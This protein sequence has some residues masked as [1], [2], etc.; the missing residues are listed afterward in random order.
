MSFD[1]T[2]YPVGATAPQ[3][4][5]APQAPEEILLGRYRV[6]A[7]RGTGG[8][9]TVCTCWDTVLQRRVAIKRMPL[10]STSPDA[11]PASTPDEVLKEA[12]TSSLLAHPN[13][14]SVL[15]FTQE[16]GYA[17]LIM[18]YVDGLNL[19]ELLARVE[20]GRLTSDECAHVLTSC[21]RALAFAHENRVLHMDIKPTNIMIDRMGTVKIADFGMA[22]LG[23]AAGYGGARGGTVGYMP[24][25]QIEG[26]LVDE[27]ADVFA[28]A[29]VIWQALTG[30]NPFA[31]ASAAASLEKIRRGPRLAHAKSATGLDLDAE[32]DLVRALAP[33]ASERTASVDELA[34]ELVPKLGDPTAGQA[35]LAELVAQSEEDDQTAE[36]PWSQR[37]IPLYMRL[38]GL[39]GVLERALPALCVLLC[40]CVVMP[41]FEGMTWE[42]KA[43]VTLA[44]CAL[45]ALWPPAAVALAG[46]AGVWAVA[47]T[48]PTSDSFVL[49]SL[50][51]LALLAWWAA[52]GRLEGMASV[53]VL[54]PWAF[55]QPLA[56]AQMAGFSLDPAEALATGAF[57]FL[58]GTVLRACAQAGYAASGAV[59]V[60]VAALTSASTWVMAG[61]AAAAA[62][63]SSLIAMRGTVAS[64]IVGQAVGLACLVAA[65][66]LKVRVENGGIWGAPEWAACLVALIWFCFMCILTVLRGPLTQSQEGE[67][68]NELP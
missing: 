6:L 16:N 50:I 28:L 3:A 1:D 8:F 7:R 35:S 17:Y 36:V 24:P 21:A 52:I 41:A 44:G 4:G 9:G 49:A 23:A 68:I 29:V 53:S 15:D 39:W 59:P 63:S 37:H 64:G 55:A 38:P 27:R 62:W 42:L 32:D 57:S 43:A 56:G 66:Y 46:G 58:M 19:A 14:V 48:S 2:D 51:G 61:G 67:D 20:D 13:V 11:I 65:N 60:I 54:A 5:E 26:M 34:C 31:A 10:F 25:E 18:E 33:I 47:T 22:E 45:T 30:K 40:A 12:R